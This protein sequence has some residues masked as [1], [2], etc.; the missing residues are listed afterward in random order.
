MPHSQ[1]GI[2]REMGN[3]QVQHVMRCPSAHPEPP[4][5]NQDW[6]SALVLRIA[7]LY[8]NPLEAMNPSTNAASNPDTP[9]ANCRLRFSMSFALAP[10]SCFSSL[11]SRPC[12]Q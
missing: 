4:Q 8:N 12:T 10:L 5:A 7:D 9:S 3:A 11:V 2:G 1:T 6:V